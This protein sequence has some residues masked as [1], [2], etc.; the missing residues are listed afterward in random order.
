MANQDG[1]WLV[2]V[3]GKLVRD[4][5]PYPIGAPAAA[6]EHETAAVTRHPNGFHVCDVPPV[7]DAARSKHDRAC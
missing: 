7:T 1:S 6:T 3:C 5:R 4:H 2:N